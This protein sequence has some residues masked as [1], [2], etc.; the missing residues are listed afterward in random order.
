MMGVIIDFPGKKGSKGKAKGNEGLIE[1]DFSGLMRRKGKDYWAAMLLR[2]AYETKSGAGRWA[3]R[4]VWEMRR[5]SLREAEETI[6]RPSIPDE[7]KKQLAK[8]LAG[9]N[10]DDAWDI[11][12]TA[13]AVVN[14]ANGKFDDR[15]FDYVLRALNAWRSGKIKEFALN[16]RKAIGSNKALSGKEKAV[17]GKMMAIALEKDDI[18]IAILTR[19]AIFYQ[20]DNSPVEEKLAK[21]ERSLETFRHL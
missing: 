19:N 15:Q 12:N 20:F 16:E 4:K 5:K 10:E 14:H 8:L 3:Q 13:M 7:K 1:E 11:E 18:A 9:T 21:V 6:S 2:G 17:L